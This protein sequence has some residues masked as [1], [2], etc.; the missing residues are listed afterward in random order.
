MIFSG[1]IDDPKE[2]EEGR[3]LVKTK[4]REKRWRVTWC[5]VSLL[6]TFIAI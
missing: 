6:L 5:G 4:Q 3:M 2:Q 1:E